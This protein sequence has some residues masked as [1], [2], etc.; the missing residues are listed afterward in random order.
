MFGRSSRGSKLSES[1]LSKLRASQLQHFLKLNPSAHPINAEQS[2]FELPIHTQYGRLTLYVHFPAAFPASP[3]V[4]Q[5]TSLVAHPYVDTDMYVVH[6]PRVLAWDAQ[7]SSAGLFLSELVAE[8]AKTPPTPVTLQQ[9][10]VREA[11]EREEKEREGKERDSEWVHVARKSSNANSPM[12]MSPVQQAAGQQAPLSSL[13]LPAAS[14]SASPLTSPPVLSAAQLAL[15]IPSSFDFLTSASLSE[16]QAFDADASLLQ[17]CLASL[18]SWQHMQHIHSDM[19]D[20]LTEQA[21][22]SLQQQPDYTRLKGEVEQARREVSGEAREVE[23]LVRRQQEV[24]NR[25]SVERTLQQLQRLGEEA[26]KRSEAMRDRYLEGGDEDG[27]AAAGGGAVGEDGA[28]ADDEK[29]VASARRGDRHSRFVEAYVKQRMAVHD[30]LAKRE[31]LMEWVAQ[32]QQHHQHA[33]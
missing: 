7:R 24:I 4:V 6:H 13:A 9:V 1:E 12:A 5:L 26:D 18:P 8:W 22:T 15:P 21:A 23:G 19:L 11:K 17:S 31:R 16:L 14:A 29:D 30:R 33:Q 3:P 32:R 28:A 10:K 20:S 27:G 25:Y 2:A